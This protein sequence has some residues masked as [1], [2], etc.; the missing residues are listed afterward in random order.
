MKATHASKLPWTAPSWVLGLVAGVLA[1]LAASAAALAVSAGERPNVVLI[2]MDNIGRDWFGCYGSDEGV[3]PEIDRLAAAGVRFNTCWATPMCS[4]SRVELLTGRYGFRTGWHTHHDASNYGGG[5]FDWERETTFARVLQS[6]GYATAIAGKWQISNLFEPD[7]KDA[8]HKHGFDEH[9]IWPGGLVDSP[10]YPRYWDP[11]IFRDGRKLDAAGR[12][13]PDVF[14]EYV[15]DGRSFAPI[16]WGQPRPRPRP[17]VFSQY[18]RTRMAGDGRFK[19]YS[20]GELFDVRQ[21]M[22]E[23][24]DLSG[25]NA[26]QA[27]K[28]RKRLQ[29]VLD[30]LPKDVDLPF[31]PRSQSAYRIQSQERQRK[32]PAELRP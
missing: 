29:A 22:D 21:E 20:T 3:T 23:R 13:G 16:L 9:C 10:G 18:Y 26:P 31:P 14:D 32:P 24:S 8:P 6:A 7:Q 5:N 28:A 2:V 12:F 15:I 4:T 30:G 11:C 19:L 1:W 25:S 17:W 27:A